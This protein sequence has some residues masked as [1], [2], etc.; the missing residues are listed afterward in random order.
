MSNKL[1]LSMD[2]VKLKHCLP[3]E[4]LRSPSLE[5]LWSCGDV[6]LSCLVNGHDGMGWDWAW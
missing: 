6:V 3:R 5:V 2:A 1:C 4:V